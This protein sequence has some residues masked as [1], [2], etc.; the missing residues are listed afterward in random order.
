MLIMEMVLFLPLTAATFNW[1]DIEVVEVV[2]VKLSRSQSLLSSWYF[3]NLRSS[4]C[5]EGRAHAHDHVSFGRN[6]IQKLIRRDIF[7]PLH[8]ELNFSSK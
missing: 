8:L 6:N 1:H 4:P 3:S 7:K 2:A 5:S